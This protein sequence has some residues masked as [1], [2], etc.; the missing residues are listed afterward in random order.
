MFSK[1]RK[2]LTQYFTT[3]D[4]MIQIGGHVAHYVYGCHVMLVTGG[5]FGYVPGQKA[6][7]KH[8]LIIGV[9]QVEL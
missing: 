7:F 9:Q 4:P 6:S 1:V 8:P 2:Y 5:A 3:E